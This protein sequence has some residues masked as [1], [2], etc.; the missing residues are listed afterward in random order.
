MLCLDQSKNS[1]FLVEIH[2][3][4][5]IFASLL[6]VDYFMPGPDQEQHFLLDLHHPDDNFTYRSTC[7]LFYA[8][9]RVRTACF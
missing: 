5:D 6:L 4:D 1:I 2:H 8:W 7:F 3:S 9:T